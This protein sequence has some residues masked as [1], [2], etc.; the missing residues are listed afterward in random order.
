MKK[1]YK[2]SHHLI[3]DDEYL[4]IVNA[5]IVDE[6]GYLFIREF[7]MRKGGVWEENWYIKDEMK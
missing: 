3:S 4:R 5:E 7:E 1:G 6:K 2:V